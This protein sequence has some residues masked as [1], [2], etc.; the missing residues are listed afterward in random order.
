MPRRLFLPALLLTA[1]L[2]PGAALADNWPQWRGPTGDS[3]SAE[4]GLPLRWGPA[5]NVLWACPL[6]DGASTPAVWGDA[7]FATGQDGDKLMAY[8][9]N[10]ADGRVV[11]SRQVGTASITRSAPRRGQGGGRGAQKFHNLQNAASPSPVTDGEVVVFHFG[12]G[13]LAAYDFAGNQLW[14]RNLQTDHGHYTIWWGHANSPVLVGDLVVS[15]CMQDSLTDLSDKTP[16]DSYV[17]AHDRRTGA[18][19]WKTLRNTDSTKESCDA[20]TTPLVRTANGRTEVI[21]VGAQQIDAYDPATGKQ[22]WCLSEFTGNRIITGPTLAGDM[23]YATRGMRGAMSGVRLGGDGRLPADAVAWS[24]TGGTPDSPTPVVWRGL[25]FWVSD[26]GIAHCV[27]AGTGALKWRERLPDD[28][29][30]S[31]LAAGGR[32]YFLNLKGKCTVVAAAERFEKLAENQLPDET[33]ASPAVADGRLY[34]RGR[35]ALYCVGEKK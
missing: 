34:V 30:A 11:W 24:H 15:V 16:A 20:Y 23:L 7:V 17:V 18:Q 22:L 25:L 29:K 33:I 9:V 13:E 35:K 1:L 4:T 10:K 31:P 21:V 14:L 2:L 12:T 3:V 5:E 32:V 27:D 19:R 6:P 28:H 8:R 26:N